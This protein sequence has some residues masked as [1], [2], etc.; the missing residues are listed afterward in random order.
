MVGPGRY[1]VESAKYTSK[2]LIPPAYH[3]GKQE[4]P[5]IFKGKKGR[6]DMY[7]ETYEVYSCM[8]NQTR[9]KK[10]TEPRTKFGKSTRD[11]E[12]SRGTFNCMMDRQP[13]KVCIP[14]PKF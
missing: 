3:F 6:R 7:S 13:M 8:G 5:G 2:H 1:R 9:S 14:M 12:S 4:R 11:R 10:R